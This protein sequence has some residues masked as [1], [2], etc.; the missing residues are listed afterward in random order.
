MR[1]KILS[2]LVVALL[3]VVVI[4]AVPLVRYVLSDVVGSAFL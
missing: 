2:T 4:G 1:S 3:S